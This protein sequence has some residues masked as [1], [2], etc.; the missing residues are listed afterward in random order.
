MDQEMRAAL[1]RGFEEGFAES[2]LG[3]E[4]ARFDKQWAKW[5]RRYQVNRYC[6]TACTIGLAVTLLY[7]V[8][9]EVPSVLPALW[10]GAQV[11]HLSLGIFINGRMER[12]LQASE[13]WLKAYCARK[14]HG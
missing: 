5:K 7:S 10:F 14:G 8:F 9:W 11:A 1:Q 13:A 12:E 3:Q 2:E 4:S 6:F